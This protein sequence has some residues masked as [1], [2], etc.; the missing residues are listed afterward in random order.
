MQDYDD[1]TLDCLIVGGGPAGLVAATYLARF[2]RRILV[3]DAGESR[4]LW[5]PRTH[6]C[7]GFPDGIGGRELLDR[8]RQQCAHHGVAMARGRVE[9]IRALDSGWFSTEVEGRARRSRTVL[10]ATG[11]RDRLPN[12][13]Q[14]ED[15][16]A[17]G[18]VRLCPVCDGYEVSGRRVGVFGS[19]PGAVREAIFLKTFTPDVT[20]I[21]D[22]PERLDEEALDLARSSGITVLEGISGMRIAEQVYEVSREHGPPLV[23]DSVYPALGCVIRSDLA[24]GLGI[25]LDDL[26]HIVTD[27]H[28]QTNRQG[29]YAAGD[30][31]HSLNQLAVAFGQAAIA[32]TAI[33][34]GLR[35]L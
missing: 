32:A 25:R 14:V 2:R 20:L 8:L 11:V 28:Q 21:A 12:L 26:G 7:P 4:A 15:A 5:I 29:V 24:E 33:H 27:D 16:I 10:L 31:V 13:P 18:M 1:E 6:N 22:H 30:V 3:V 23:F 9:A 34:N 19:G 35:A 17:R